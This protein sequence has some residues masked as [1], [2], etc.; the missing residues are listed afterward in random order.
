MAAFAALAVAAQSAAAAAPAA[1]PSFAAHDAQANE[2]LAH[3]TLAE[4]IGQMTQA[5]MTSLG[6]FSDVAKLALGS[7]LCG[8]GSD[9]REGNSLEAWTDAYDACQKHA[10]ASRLKI[11]LLFGI[12]AMHGHSN[13]L[14]AVI[15]PHNIGLG[16]ARNPEL[17]RR[18]GEITAL[19]DR[20]GGWIGDLTAER[21]EHLVFYR[22]TLQVPTARYGDAVT[23]LKEM[24]TQV[25]SESRSTEDV[26]DQIVDLEARLETLRGVEV[27]LRALLAESRRQGRDVAAIMEIYR[28]LTEIRTQIEQLD[29]RLANLDRETALAAIQV[30]LSPDAAARP[31]LAD[32]WRPGETF[33]GAVAM[34]VAVLQGLADV[35]IVAAVFLLP[36]GAL[37]GL[38]VL[39]A[40]RLPWPSASSVMTR[41]KPLRLA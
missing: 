20:L 18:I 15:F 33:R 17:L 34:L 16:A 6:D 30:S 5:E 21:R 39:A 40:V 36:L 3:M 19:A 4:K 27:E 37:I 24:A 14:G 35:A 11:P 8:G 38:G 29:A 26:T 12:D 13:V 9:P 23:E 1:P 2:W 7:V 31:I 32:D 10:L 22:L 41:A 25:E 28:Q